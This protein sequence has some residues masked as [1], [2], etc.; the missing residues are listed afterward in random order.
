LSGNTGFP[1]DAARE[2]CIH[3]YGFVT[4]TM[5]RSLLTLSLA[6]AAFSSTGC[7]E[8]T[9]ELL[10]PTAPSEVPGVAA[11][12]GGGALIGLWT[13]QASVEIP[14]ARDCSAF[15]WNITSQTPTSIAGSFSAICSGVVTVTGTAS[16]QL[17]G[18][19]VPFEVT[20]G[21]AIGGVTVCPFVLRGTGVIEGTDAIRIPYTGETCLGPVHGEETLRRPPSARTV[22]SSGHA[23]EP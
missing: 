17:N 11:P 15:Q 5:K 10:T 22:A 12:S 14:A 13:S 19:Q 20:G 8:H 9:S 21:A 3:A 7:S 16:G 23:T 18:N 6:V 4:M 1:V 2:S